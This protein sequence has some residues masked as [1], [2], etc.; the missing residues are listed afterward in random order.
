MLGSI[1]RIQHRNRGIILRIDCSELASI[2]NVGDSVSV[3]GICLTIVS[4]EIGLLIFNV[5]P[6]TI[7]KTTISRWR[8]KDTVNLE[9]P[10]AVDSLFHGHLV[11]GHVDCVGRITHKR[12][13]SDYYEI[14]VNIPLEYIKYI[15]VKGSIAIDGVSLTVVKVNRT[16]NFSI[17]V[18][19]HTYSTTIIQYYKSNSYVNI[20]V[21]ILAKYISNNIQLL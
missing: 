11:Q 6:E 12:S 1:A 9:S 8:V 5:S 14:F 15:V 21:D 2:I 7:T 3:N 4:K 19:P 18:I 16:G 13:E 10:L 17:N 20:E